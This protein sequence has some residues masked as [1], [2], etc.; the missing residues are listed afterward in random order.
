MLKKHQPNYLNFF[1]IRRA[2]VPPPWYEYVNIPIKYNL[3]A[4]V[5]KW[6]TENLKGRFYIGKSITISASGQI[7][8]ILKIGFENTKECSYFTLACPHLKYN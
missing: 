2:K 4:S 1:E 7:E 5:S 3:E 6:I 8:T